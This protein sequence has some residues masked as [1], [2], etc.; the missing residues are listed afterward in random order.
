MNRE[1]ETEDF[2]SVHSSNAHNSWDWVRMKPGTKSQSRAPTWV[3]G[4]QVLESLAVSK[5]VFASMNL[6]SEVKS[7]LEPR[8]L[9][10]PNDRSASPCVFC[11]CF[12]IN[13]FD[14]QRENLPYTGS[15]CRCP[16]DM[17]GQPRNQ[18]LHL[19]LPHRLHESKYL[20]HHMLPPQHISRKLNQK[21][22]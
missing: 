3:T 7:R 5:G 22:V 2:L 13:L 12:L 19:G 15:L 16:E 14:R 11:F 4:N 1:T 17:P 8:H 20:G 9:I 6:E 10:W 21:L 18:K